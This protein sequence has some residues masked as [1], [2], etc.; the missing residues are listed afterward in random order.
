MFLALNQFN[1]PLHI[2][3]I[4]KQL[5]NKE[6]L[7]SPHTLLKT[8]SNKYLLGL[9]IGTLTPNRCQTLTF[10]NQ[11]HI[12]LCVHDLADVQIIEAYR[13]SDHVFSQ[14]YEY[15]NA[16]KITGIKLKMTIF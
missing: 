16:L 6:T 5:D 12:R 3:F 7:E 14:I 11:I 9:L 15:K 4:N 2:V 10:N 1:D 13:Y 8:M